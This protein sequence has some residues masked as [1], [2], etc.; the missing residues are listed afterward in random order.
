MKD[1]IEYFTATT[2]FNQD[3]IPR[4]AVRLIFLNAQ[5]GWLRVYERDPTGRATLIKDL[6]PLRTTPEIS[7]YFDVVEDVPGQSARIYIFQ[8]FH[9]Q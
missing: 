4:Y 7:E 3:K 9:T 1:G 6:R 5:P 8:R 2:S